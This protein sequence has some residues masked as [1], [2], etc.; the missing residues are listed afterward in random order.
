MKFAKCMVLIA[1]LVI[2]GALG[3]SESGDPMF[4][5][6]NETSSHSCDNDDDCLD[7]EVCYREVCYESCTEMT[8]CDADYGCA[9][10]R[11]VPLDCEGVECEDDEICYR[12]VCYDSCE[13]EGDCDSEESCVGERCAPPDCDEMTCLDSEICYRG[14][15][16]DHCEDD[17]ECDGLKSCVQGICQ[18]EEE[19]CADGDCASDEECIQGQCQCIHE[20]CS[21]AD[22]QGLK[23]CQ[24]NQCLCEQGCC[25]DDDCSQDLVC[26]FRH[27]CIPEDQECEDSCDCPHTTEDRDYSR[28]AGNE[29]YYSTTVAGPAPPPERP[30]CSDFGCAQGDE[31]TKP[32]GSTGQC[33]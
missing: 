9:A 29:C 11:C 16:Y 10:E 14:V 18:C 7:E 32:D 5:D 23:T 26:N 6:S 22:C 28:C 15:C 12:G 31:C 8:D 2:G 13:T 1:L 3:C 19:C 25:V 17:E 21:D 27:E 20:C 24:D 30:C 33:E 4:D